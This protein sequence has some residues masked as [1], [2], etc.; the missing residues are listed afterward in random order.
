MESTLGGCTLLAST[1]PSAICLWVFTTSKGRV[2]VAAT[3][4][5][6]PPAT[7]LTPT[8]VWS[9]GLSPFSQLFTSS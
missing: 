7:K 6:M 3:I 2:R 9:F 1:A 8:D 5:E 4:P